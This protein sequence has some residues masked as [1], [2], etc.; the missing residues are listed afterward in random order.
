MMVH[1]MA[2]ADYLNYK[3]LKLENG[4]AFRQQTSVVA[5]PMDGGHASR[6]E[7]RTIG[8]AYGRR[9]VKLIEAGTF[10][11][12]SVDIWR[13]HDWVSIAAKPIGPLL[14]NHDVQ[15]VWLATHHLSL[16]LVGGQLPTGVRMVRSLSLAMLS[17]PALPPVL[18]PP[19]P[20]FRSK[21][22]TASVMSGRSWPAGSW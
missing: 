3:T 19:R 6:H 14:V 12:N 15:K 17:I 13:L 16:P 22:K 10:G 21:P 2:S 7:T 8:H 9:N 1:P 5:Q 4:G 20:T 18:R 11:R